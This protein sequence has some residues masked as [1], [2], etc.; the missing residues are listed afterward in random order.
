MRNGPRS[1]L[2]ILATALLV[3]SACSDAASVSPSAVAS[4]PLVRLSVAPR[5]VQL[6]LG[7]SVELVAYAHEANGDSVVTPVTWSSRIGTISAGGWYR[8]VHQGLDTVRARSTVESSLTDAATI[9]VTAPA[10][11]LRS[12]ATARGFLIGAAVR[13]SAFS[14]DAQYRQTLVSQYNSIVPEDA[15][16]FWPIHPGPTQY[17]FAPADSLVAFA[18]AN[19]MTFHGHSL[20]WYAWIPTWVTGGGYS[21]AQLRDI[22][23][24]HITTVVGRYRGK[25][26]TWD[27]VNEALDNQG[28][29]SSTCGLQPSFWLTHLGPE[30]IDS[31]FVWARRADPA[32]KLYLDDYRT[33]VANFKSDTL[34]ALAKGLKARGIPIDGIGF[35]VHILKQYFGVPTSAD[36]Q[37]NFQRFADAGFDIRITEMDAQI[38]DTAGASELAVQAT[39]YNNVLDACLKVTRCKELTTWGFTDRFS[40]VPASFPGYGRALP[41]DLNYQPKPAFNAL[42]ARLGIP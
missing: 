10:P 8:A 40:W 2:S 6:A 4:S 15:T 35:Q 1:M 3:S 33:E 34:L 29:F 24:N 26:A 23:K 25:A 13:D 28:C 21:D 12:L 7:D 14:R 17:N 19:G 11:T 20:V 39:I 41:F 30:Y 32:A 22:L 16:D 37:A 5:A 36:M 31:S 27:V 38:A 9:G 42:L 18:Q